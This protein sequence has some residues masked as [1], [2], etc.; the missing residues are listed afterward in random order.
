MVFFPFGYCLSP[1]PEIR[2]LHANLVRQY[3]CHYHIILF[4]LCIYHCIVCE[5]GNKFYYILFYSHCKYHMN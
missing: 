2:Q 1:G 5:I 3:N 4:S